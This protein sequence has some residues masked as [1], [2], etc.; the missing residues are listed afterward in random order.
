L[1]SSDHTRVGA[2]PSPGG[3]GAEL[4]APADSEPPCPLAAF[5]PALETFRRGEGHDRRAVRR[6][7]LRA[8]THTRALRHDR[9]AVRWR[10]RR[11][12]THTRTVGREWR[13]RLASRFFR[14]TPETLLA[15][16][17][18]RAEPT[19]AS[20]GRAS[21]MGTSAPIAIAAITAA[22][23]RQAPP[24]NARAAV[25][26]S[27]ASLISRPCRRAKHVICV[28]SACA[29]L[30][31]RRTYRNRGF[32]QA[33]KGRHPRA[34]S[35]RRPSPSDGQVESPLTRWQLT[36]HPRRL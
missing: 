29:Q 18:T 33:G 4:A 9:R 2:E 21:A 5:R 26:P 25:S 3:V 24:P 28:R 8:A 34:P 11:A 7:S 31:L 22:R 13:L 32:V 23:R 30:A 15:L 1:N 19:A 16:T 6:R 35:T 14:A 27:E 10:W 17:E 36:R 20:P 12:E